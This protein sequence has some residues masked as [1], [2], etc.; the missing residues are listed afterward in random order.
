MRCI[1][2]DSHQLEAYYGVD[3]TIVALVFL[4]PF[5]GYILA[6]ISNSAIH[7][8]YG[9]FG[10]AVVAPLCKVIAFVVFCIHPPFAVL[11]VVYVVCGFGNGL[12]DGGWNAWIGN[13][14]N[15]SEIMGILHAAYGLGATLSPLIAT[16]MV[17]KG[18]LQWYTFY[19]L[20]VCVVRCSAPQLIFQ[21]GLAVIEWAICAYA[22]RSATGTTVRAVEAHEQPNDESG[23]AHTGEALKNSTTWLTALFLFCSTGV[24]VGIGGW[25]VTFMLNVRNGDDFDSGMVVTGYWLGMTIGRLTLGFITGRIGE[26]LAVCGYLLLCVALQLCFWLIPSFIASAVFVAWLGFFVG[27]LFPAA[28]VVATKVLPQKLHVSAIGFAAASGSGGG[29]VL[30]FAIG[31]IVQAK[32]VWVLQPIILALIVVV[33]AVWLMLSSSPRRVVRQGRA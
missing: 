14:S 25:L 31:A 20:M 28:I 3:Y 11:P 30:P 6:A 10:I 9:Q 26:R 4:A 1:K 23:L 21:V 8:R 17:T 16:S 24:E 7:N 22:F 18:N 32:G 2:T 19:Y 5:V 29:S 12:E 13:M 15:A 33:L 27:P